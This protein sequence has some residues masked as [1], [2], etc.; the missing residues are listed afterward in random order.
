MT[1]K[2]LEEHIN[3]T[4]SARCAWL[5]FFARWQ[6]RSNGP[7]FATLDDNDPENKALDENRNA[8]PPV[9]SCRWTNMQPKWRN[10]LT[11][12]ILKWQNSLLIWPLL[13]ILMNT[14]TWQIRQLPFLRLDFFIP[15]E[16]LH[17]LFFF[18]IRT[19]KIRLRL[20]L[21]LGFRHLSIKKCS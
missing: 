13:F 21:F 12:G 7:Y 15:P 6:A 4:Y 8:A 1:L 16:T 20:W 14:M 5:Q 19:S 2:I 18:F 11:R 3:C 17:T 9:L 10:C